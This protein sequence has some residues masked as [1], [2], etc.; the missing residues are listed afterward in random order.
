MN[1]LKISILSGAALMIL[2]QSCQQPQADQATIDAKISETFAAEKTKIE[3]EAATACEDAINTKVKAMQDSFATL[4]AAQQAAAQAKMQRD[5]KTAQA[6]ADAAKK[7]KAAADAAA[8][9]KAADAAK[10]VVVKDPAAG[11]KNKMNN[12]ENAVQEVTKEQTE[13][14]KDKM[15]RGED[16]VIPVTEEQTKAK[17]SKMNGG[18]N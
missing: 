14:K 2:A 10:K 16:A 17:K 12:G 6:K 1:K 15:N 8:K 13:A 18:G 9:K 3:N 7:K 4:G 5:L 11:K